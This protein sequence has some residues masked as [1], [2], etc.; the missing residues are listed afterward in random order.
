[1][2]EDARLD[3]EFSLNVV[4][5][6]PLD[7]LI[8]SGTITAEATGTAGKSHQLHFVYIVKYSPSV[9]NS[10]FEDM[11][12]IS[13]IIYNDN[14]STE[15]R[16]FTVNDEITLEYEDR[17]LLRFNPG[18]ASLIP[19]LESRNEC[20]RD[21]ATVN[22]IDNDRKYIEGIIFMNSLSSIAD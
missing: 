4:G 7:T 12:P 2:N 17:A 10:D 16:L 13:V 3:T 5:M 15:I 9:A 6:T 22:I 18:S 14:P 21:T 11:T 19:G 8:V 1:M 20:V